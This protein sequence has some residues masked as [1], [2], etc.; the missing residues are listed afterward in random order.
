MPKGKPQLLQ[1][2]HCLCA[3][4]GHKLLHIGLGGLK[5]FS[6]KLLRQ[7]LTRGL[8]TTELYT[9]W[10]ARKQGRLSDL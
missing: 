10:Q 7:D 4:G 3:T 2:M 9:A 1:C 8:S 5:M 6:E